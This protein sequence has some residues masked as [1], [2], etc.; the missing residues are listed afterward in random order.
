MNILRRKSGKP[1]LIRGPITLNLQP[2]DLRGSTSRHRRIMVSAHTK[3]V[4]SVSVWIQDQ[5]MAAGV[6]LDEE[7]M[8]R[9]VKGLHDALEASKAIAASPETS[10]DG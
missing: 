2:K 4:P 10:Q 6:F 1:K 8:G 9:L 5:N 3:D 7:E